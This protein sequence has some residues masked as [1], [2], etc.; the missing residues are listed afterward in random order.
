MVSKEFHASRRKRYAELLEDDCAAFVFA[1]N[2]LPDKGMNC[3]RS[4]PTPTSIISPGLTSP[5]RC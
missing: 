5:K 4:H 1:G 2:E 3:T